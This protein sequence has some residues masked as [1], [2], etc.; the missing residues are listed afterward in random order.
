MFM[1]S[2]QGMFSFCCRDDAAVDSRGSRRSGSR[3]GGSHGPDGSRHSSGPAGEAGTDAGAEEDQDQQ[4]EQEP[5][6]SPRTL[7]PPGVSR[8][9]RMEVHFR[10]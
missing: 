8:I 1:M 5:L 4:Q 9:G 3:S 10:E 7:L 6:A 2:I